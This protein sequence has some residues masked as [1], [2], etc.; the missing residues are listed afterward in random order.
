MADAPLT[1]RLAKPDDIPAL[2]ELM[3]AA[4]AQLQKS[5]LSDAQIASSR[6]IM[7]LDRQLID[8]RTYFIVECGGRLAGSGGWSR[9]ATLYGGDHSPAATPPCWIRPRTRRGSGPCTPRRTSPGG[10]SAG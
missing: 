8:D 5:F 6:M 9:R 7:G 3:D 2:A 1:H 10:A 4:I